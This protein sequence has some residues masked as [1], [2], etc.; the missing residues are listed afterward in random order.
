MALLFFLP[1]PGKW[2]F[3]H[4][5][6]VHSSRIIHGGTAP[7]FFCCCYLESF[8]DLVFSSPQKL[9]RGWFLPHVSYVTNIV[10]LIT[11]IHK[12]YMIQISILS[13]YYMV[14]CNFLNRCSESLKNMGTFLR[15]ARHLDIKNLF[16]QIQLQ[17]LKAIHNQNHLKHVQTMKN[18][19]RCQSFMS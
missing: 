16:L 10:L 4:R 9:V 8:Q 14:Y 19:L 12:N 13:Y 1:T 2:Y 18:V 11:Y 5:S 15:S 7:L 3:S 17:H 6:E